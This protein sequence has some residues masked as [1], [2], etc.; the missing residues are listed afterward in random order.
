MTKKPKLDDAKGPPLW[1]ADLKSPAAF[2]RAAGQRALDQEVLLTRWI[3]A[4]LLAVNGGAILAMAQSGLLHGTP[5][6]T[7]GLFV[8]GIVVAIVAALVAAEDHSKFAVAMA[9]F[10]VFSEL[11]EAYHAA[12]K[13][14][15]PDEI[16]KGLVLLDR[17]IKQAEKS[18]KRVDRKIDS[19]KLMYCS[20]TF[21]VLG[22]IAVG[23][24]LA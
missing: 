23:Y 6:Y 7:A 4:S 21:F 16:D 2:A 13:D 18:L 14:G 11:M 15:E 1:E 24:Q 5:A 19:T 20:L 12:S 22:A 3:M 8:I 17:Q 9:D 10:E